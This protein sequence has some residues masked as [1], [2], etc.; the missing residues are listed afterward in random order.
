[1]L[2][3]FQLPVPSC[4]AIYHIL[5]DND[6]I[7]AREKASS[8]EKEHP[9]PIACWQIDFKDVSSIPADPDGKQ[10]HSV[11]TLNFIDTGTSIQLDAHVRSDFTVETALEALALTLAKY[12]LPKKVTL[13]R[14]PRWIGSPA[15]CDFPAALLRFGACLGIEIEV[16]AT[17]HPQQN[18]FVERYNR[19][20]QEECLALDRPTTLE[21]VRSVTETFVR[22]A[23]SSGDFLWQSSATDC[24]PNTC[25]FTPITRDGGLRRLTQ[26]A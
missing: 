20:Y 5:K 26:D 3:F 24:I 6:C 18:G 19:T 22:G 8:S 14:D 17:H 25:P 4:K 2:Y 11:E 1:M 10:Q 7:Q 9:A 16:C 13:D 23:T 21:Q 15:G 12:G